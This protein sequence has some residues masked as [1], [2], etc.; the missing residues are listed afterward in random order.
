V[1]ELSHFFDC[2]RSGEPNCI[3]GKAGRDSLEIFE[4]AYMSAEKKKPVRLPII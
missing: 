2:C 4:A 1:A 3:P